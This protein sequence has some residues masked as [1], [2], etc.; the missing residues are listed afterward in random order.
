MKKLIVLFLM[1]IAISTI[2]GQ[3]KKELYN[4]LK[5]IEG[6]IKSLTIT[7][8]KGN[9]TFKGDDAE[10]LLKKLKSA[11]KQ[12]SFRIVIPEFDDDFCDSTNNIMMWLDKGNFKFNLDSLNK[13]FNFNFNFNGTDSGLVTKKIDINMEG[14]DTTLCVTTTQNGETTTKIYTGKEATDFI[15]KHE[16]DS[17]DK[18]KKK[19]III[20][21]FKSKDDE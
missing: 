1:F 20:K 7:T 16:A 8:D 15:K 10:Y 11:I 18:N 12:K 14:S 4:K 13:K 3:S 9:V 19:K 5:G 17:S 2:L 21:E 6:D